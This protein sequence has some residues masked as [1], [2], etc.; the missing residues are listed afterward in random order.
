M[1]GLRFCQS[2]TCERWYQLKPELR[3]GPPS[4][5]SG[6]VCSGAL[7]GGLRFWH[8]SGVQ[9]FSANDTG[10]LRFAATPGYF[11]PPLRGGRLK[12]ELCAG[13]AVIW[14][15]VSHLPPRALSRSKSSVLR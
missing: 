2:A 3:A 11:L 15:F 5:P 12:L 8:P 7:E 6:L 9:A 4:Q 13:T 10:G 1:L 14:R